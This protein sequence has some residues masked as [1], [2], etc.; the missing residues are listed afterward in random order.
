MGVLSLLGETVGGQSAAAFYSTIGLAGTVVYLVSLAI[1]R[2]YFS[3]LS[4]FPGPK[5]AALTQWYEAY[6]ELFHGDGGQ[7]IWHYAKLHEKYG[8]RLPS[9]NSTAL[10]Q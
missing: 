3:P 5:L 10:H 6:Y 2:L 9:P 8:K 1:Y 7:F 4:K